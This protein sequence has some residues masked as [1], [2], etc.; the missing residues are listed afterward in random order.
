MA[1][2]DWG[3]G[4][5]LSGLFGSL[6]DNFQSTVQAATNRTIRQAEEDAAAQDAE[7]YDQWV[8]GMLTDEAWMTY[9]D[10]RLAESGGDAEKVQRWTETK[11][12]HGQ[13]IADGKVESSY[14]AGE[15]SIHELIAHY[16]TRMGEVE[17]SSPEWRETSDR[18][19]DLVDKRDADYIDDQSMI[20]VDKIERGSA[21]YTDLLAFY[22]EMAGKVRSSSPLSSQIKRQITNIRQIVD[23]VG[24]S[25]SGGGGGG[26][27]RGGGSGGSGGGGNEDGLSGDLIQRVNDVLTDRY[28]LGNVF[29]PTGENIVQTVFDLFDVESNK[30]AILDAME[31]DSRYIEQ[32]M[33]RW[34][35]DP[36]G[37]TLRTAFGQEIPNTQANRWAVYSQAIATYDFRSGLMNATG[38]WDGAAMVQGA[39]DAFVQNTMQFDNELTTRAVWDVQREGFNQ[40]MN[41]AKTAPDPDVALRQ[42]N[43]AGAAL[44]TTASRLLRKND[45]MPPELQMDEF[46]VDELRFSE[47]ISNLVR[48]AKDMSPEEIQTYGSMLLDDRPDSFYLSAEQITE[49]IGNTEGPTGSGMAG[50]A[51]AREGLRATRDT[52]RGIFTDVEPYVYVSLPGQSAPQLVKQSMVS[53]FLKTEEDDWKLAVRPFAERVGRNVEI[54][55]RPLE[56]RAAEKW[57]KDKQGRWVTEKAFREVGRDA[58]AIAEK[59]WEYVEIP[60]FVG[61]QTVEDGKGITWYVDPNDGQMYKKM[62]FRGG[63]TGQFDVA[64]LLGNGGKLERVQGAEGYVMGVGYGVSGRTAQGL[65]ER[66]AANGEI[67]MT[68]YHRRNTGTGYVEPDPMGLDDLGSMFWDPSDVSVAELNRRRGTRPDQNMFDYEQR[69]QKEHQ[70]DII[71]RQEMQRIGRVREWYDTEA[72]KLYDRTRFVERKAFDDPI[73]RGARQAGIT[74]LRYN[75]RDPK[76]GE[77]AP[78]LKMDPKETTPA[79]STTQP[80]SIAAV[81][82]PAMALGDP[83]ITTPLPSTVPNTPPRKP[84]YVKSPVRNTVK[85]KTPQHKTTGTSGARVI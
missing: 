66:A 32:M 50:A 48:G 77:P 81:K 28:R 34:K 72:G 54:V 49:M 24:Q 22:Q 46:L 53:E 21:S 14:Q 74:L 85:S 84:E 30:T 9:I 2:R 8:N 23:G 68:I 69:K 1:Q 55:Y 40:S 78:Q 65:A 51:A 73:T 13:A 36:E 5:D 63:I 67:D 52:R 64:E 76:Q 38:D 41:L 56:P 39:R 47:G 12:K 83:K 26:G 29:V 17:R 62:P 16:N 59:G 25:R 71:K 31:A 11:R 45:E 19:Y 61:W 6:I 27:G 82:A 42:F 18:Y 37:K 7:T 3:G 70:K 58:G 44:W 43:R 35:D 75:Q 79:R 57:Y 10:K 20:I 33:A 80:V 4:G 60:E 15:I